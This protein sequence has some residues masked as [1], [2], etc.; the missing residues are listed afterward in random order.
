M[1]ELHALSALQDPEQASEAAQSLLAPDPVTIQPPPNTT[2]I[3]PAGV[4][5]SDGR[6]VR[7]AEVRE[8]NGEDE[9]ALSRGG[10]SST[11]IKYMN[12]LLSRAVVSIDGR[13][14][15]PLA[16]QALLAGDRTALLMGIRRATY[17]DDIDMALECSKCQ[18]KFEAT[19]NLVEDVKTRSL[20]NP[21]QRESEVL[22]RSGK[23]ASV[24]YINGADQEY[25]YGDG[26]LTLAEQ[27]TRLLS[28]VVTKIDG[29]PV[30]GEDPIRKMG[31]QDRNTLLRW[32]NDNAPGPLLGEV[33]VPCHFCGEVSPL[34]IGL[35]DLF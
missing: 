17:G 5:T 15:D 30:L 28:R 3:L 21:M 26:T 16:L 29:K 33:S 14:P 10:A 19:V 23:Y 6:L 32:V 35:L 13:Q 34:A 8:L 4:I 25:A 7:E 31:L 2:V 1:S 22:L 12:T 9:E 20:D 18:G 11:P 27:N 24:R